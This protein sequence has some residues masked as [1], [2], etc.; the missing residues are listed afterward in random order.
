MHS[1]DGKIEIV[2]QGLQCARGCNVPGAA[3][4]LCYEARRRRL[5]GPHKAGSA[6]AGSAKA[7]TVKTSAVE[8]KGQT[9][10]NDD[11]AAMAEALLPVVLAA[12]AVELRYFK[13]GVAVETKDDDSPVTAADREAEDIISEALARH[14]PDIPVVGEEAASDGRLP[15][16]EGTFFLVDPLDGTRDFVAG[17][18]EFT[19]N[20]ALVVDYQP[21]FGAV[22][23]PRTERLFLTLAGDRAIEAKVS[24][25]S[26]CSRLDQLT[27]TRL[28]TR[29]PDPAALKVAVSQ[30]HPSSQLESK[31]RQLGIRQR[32]QAGSSLKF[33]LVAR[34]DAD[35]Y[36]RL[37]SISEWDTAAGQAV[38]QAAGGAVSGLD[39]CNLAYGNAD[40]AFRVAPFVA[41]GRTS[42]SQIISFL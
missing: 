38:L 23:Q 36:P 16:V 33:C 15:A 13:S 40:K 37:T 9:M 25:T 21:L 24:A 3:M 11:H 26:G 10:Q 39:N 34:G 31:L 12:G 4:W 30:S 17:R 41:W 7:G 42:L 1:G 5:P 27:A 20:V 2:A 35:I 32:L 8:D 14:Y 22:Y 6:K 19:V 18:D 28:A 29:E